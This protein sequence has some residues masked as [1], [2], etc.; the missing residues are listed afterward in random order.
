MGWQREYQARKTKKFD[1]SDTLVVSTR[2]AKVPQ[3][4]KEALPD[5]QTQQAQALHYGYNLSQVPV[6]PKHPT[7]AFGDTYEQ[8]V[9]QPEEQVPAC[10]LLHPAEVRV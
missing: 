6:H 2:S 10:V 1:A 8:E 7:G 4:K 5:L 3:R 9:A